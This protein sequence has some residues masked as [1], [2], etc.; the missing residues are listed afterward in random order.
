MNIKQ[1][2]CIGRLCIFYI[3]CYFKDD[4][5]GFSKYIIECGTVFIKLFQYFSMQKGILPKKLIKELS[6][7]QD[8]VYNRTIT[9]Y[10][11]IIENNGIV[12]DEKD[13]KSVNSGSIAQVFE[14]LYEGNRVA[15]KI[16]HP[17]IHHKISEEIEMLRG[18]VF[19]LKKLPI[20]KH[21]VYMLNID[22]FADDI[23][24]QTNFLKEKENI[25]Y[26]RKKFK[27]CDS[28][29]IPT[30]FYASEDM[31]IM[32]WEKGVK[33]TDFISSNPEHKNTTLSLLFCVWI[34][35]IKHD[36]I[37]HGDIHPGNF[38]ITMKTGTIKLVILDF[39]IIFKMKSK[40][41]MFWSKFL[42]YNT[43]ADPYS[44]Q[45]IIIINQNKNSSNY[46]L[47]ND[48]SKVSTNVLELYSCIEKTYTKKKNYIDRKYLDQ[49]FRFNDMNKVVE[50]CWRNKV[51][52]DSRNLQIIS[53]SMNF[54][55]ML[56]HYGIKNHTKFY[57]E[58]YIYGVDNGILKKNTH[59][60]FLMG[61]E[62][63]RRSTR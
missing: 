27:K 45:N 11:H 39:G 38:L 22:D 25:E 17:G 6:K 46:N 49:K 5:D 1:L 41:I 8:S 34:K 56:E 12:I 29:I 14:T 31:I 57:S 53:F 58:S 3:V 15:V 19:F 4:Y 37:T 62:I 36:N 23:I 28:V 63:L 55:R 60:D 35:M 43:I 52:F 40:D 48:L 21:F 30:V 61:L 7:L 42:K 16:R 44:V 32:S 50:I 47:M 54:L 33:Y 2:I 51:V 59:L 18:F 24:V 13:L 9:D 20:L 26:F 10:R